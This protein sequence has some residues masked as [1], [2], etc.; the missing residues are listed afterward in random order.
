MDPT[1]AAP[2]PSL[3]ALDLPQLVEVLARLDQPAWRARQVWR[4]LYVGL[5]DDVAQ[6]TDLPIGLRRSLAA[7]FRLHTIAAETTTDSHDSPATKFLFRLRDG[8]F[9]ET[10]LMHYGDEAAEA[11][12]DDAPSGP[13][14]ART[15]PASSAGAERH[16][17]CLSTQAGCAMGCVFCATGQMG[18]LR[19]LDRGE[20]VEQVVWCARA[21]A[22]D[23]RRLSHVV[24]MGMGEPLANWAATWGTVETLTDPDGLHLSARRLTLSTV[25]IV[26]GID[27]LAAMGKPVRLAVSLHA[28]DDALRSRLVAVNRVYGL[29]AILDACRRYQAAGGRR[30][31]FEYVLIDGVNDRVAQAEA[32]A[33]SLRG[34]RS[35]VN[36]IPL[37]PTAGSPLRPSPP[38]RALAFRDA[39]QR[40]GLGSTLRLR[41][42]I[43]IQAGCGQLRMR[44]E[45]PVGRT[46]PLELSP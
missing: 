45:G 17:V 21:L 7:R 22:R 27:R 9:V 33:R 40:A 44:V 36:L 41:R 11:P 25:G 10:V 20:C 31:T 4:W 39:L 38:D 46:L 6:M 28:P 12:D 32:L 2:L 29:A 42:G 5:V 37:N 16:T 8:A 1:A 19:D 15:A 34:L 23:G 18:L 14:E 13:L 26:P 43:D 24:F 30:I 3:Y 35:H